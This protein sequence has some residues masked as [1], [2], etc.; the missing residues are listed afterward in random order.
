MQMLAASRTESFHKIEPLSRRGPFIPQIGFRNG[1]AG[2]EHIF[3]KDRKPL[4]G[5][6][7]KHISKLMIPTP[8]SP[9]HSAKYSGKSPYFGRF[10]SE[11]TCSVRSLSISNTKKR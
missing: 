8:Q 10:E 1:I 5:V 6:V 7:D 11:L 4:G 2:F 3:R 9:Q